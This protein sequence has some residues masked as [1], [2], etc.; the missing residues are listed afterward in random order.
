MTAL[1]GRALLTGALGSFGRS[2]AEALAMAGAAIIL[3]DWP[4]HPDKKSSKVIDR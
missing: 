1:S 4:K 2:Q 3:W